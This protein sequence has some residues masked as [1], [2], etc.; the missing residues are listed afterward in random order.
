MA[1]PRACRSPHRNFPPTGKD[2]VAEASP[3]EGSGTL[4]PMPA[5]AHVLTPYSAIEMAGTRACS[6]PCQNPSP[7]KR[8]INEPAEQAPGALINSSGFC[9]FTLNPPPLPTPVES[10]SQSR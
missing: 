10:Y 4:T 2:E 5:L 8:V 9:T 6:S 1:G 7:V 3:T